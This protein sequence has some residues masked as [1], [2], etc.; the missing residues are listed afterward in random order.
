MSFL[1]HIFPEKSAHRDGLYLFSDSR[2]H[3]REGDIDCLEQ[4]CPAEIVLVSC[5]IAL[6]NHQQTGEIYSFLSDAYSLNFYHLVF[7]WSAGECPMLLV[8]RKCFNQ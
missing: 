3:S 2:V 7:V 8:G 4:K 1:S 5:S 6:R